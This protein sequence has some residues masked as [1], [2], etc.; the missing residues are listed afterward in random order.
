MKSDGKKNFTMGS[1]K[2]S[3]WRWLLAPF[4]VIYSVAVEFRNQLF[5]L[6]ILKSREFDVPLISVG[7]IT[8]GG[9]GKTP[10]VEYLIK[11]LRNSYTIAVL[12]RGYK[13]RKKGFQYVADGSTSSDVGDEPKQIKHKFPDVTVAVGARRIS[14]IK[15]LMDKKETIDAIVLDDAYQHRYVS[16]G[17]SILLIDYNR[18]MSE[19]HILPLGELREPSREM[20][21]A[22]IIIVTNTPHELKPIEK[23]LLHKRLKPYPYQDVFFSYVDY[24]ELTPINPRGK[25]NPVTN[26]DINEKEYAVLLVT[27]IAKSGEVYKHINKYTQNIKQIEFGD[28]HRYKNRDIQ[29]IKKEFDAMDAENKIILTTEKDAVKLIEKSD[30]PEEI[31]MNSYY[32]PLEVQLRHNDEADFNQSI[33]RYVKTNKRHDSLFRK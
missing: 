27:G 14:G 16:A 28:H 23:R 3:P 12:S 31:M 1:N 9:T 19:D 22:N 10:H 25:M 20:W 13:R 4:A 24:G 5:D 11:L 18:P 17:V 26:T 21:R 8:V 30:L 7:N 15:K 2:K 32:F 29:R 6:G 33:Y